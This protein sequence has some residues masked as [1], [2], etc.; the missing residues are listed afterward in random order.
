M[1]EEIRSFTPPDILR[2]QKYR[3]YKGGEYMVICEMIHSET[4]EELIAYRY[5]G[6]K[7]SDGRVWARPKKMFFGMVVVD[8][9]EIPRFALMTE[10]KQ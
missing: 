5:V 1:S 2:G 10:S 8:G 3:H 9:K 4:K 6:P 7:D